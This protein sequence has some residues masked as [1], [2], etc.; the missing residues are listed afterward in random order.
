MRC[1]LSSQ[2]G[3]A[4]SALH[5]STK[6][7]GFLLLDGASENLLF[8]TTT[9]IQGAAA[10]RVSFSYKNPIADVCYFPNQEADSG[11]T[12]RNGGKREGG[13]A[14]ALTKSALGRQ[15]GRGI[16]MRQTKTRWLTTVAILLLVAPLALWAEPPPSDST[17]N[18]VTIDG[19][20]YENCKVVRVE[21][22][23]VVVQHKS[24]GAKVLFRVMSDDL[25]K[26]YGHDPDKERTYLKQLEAAKVARQKRDFLARVKP[27]FGEVA[28]GKVGKLAYPAEIISVVGPDEMIVRVRVDSESI[29]LVPQLMVTRRGPGGD[30]MDYL[31]VPVKAI[32]GTPHVLWTKGIPTDGLV[33]GKKIQL[34]GVYRVTR[35]RTYDT[36]AGGTSTVFV[37]EPFVF[38][39]SP[40]V[41]E[42][43]GVRR[44]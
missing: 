39:S 2:C 44:Q 42:P 1:S 9:P 13:S 10:T 21:P 32:K 5:C 26:K 29:E 19:K 20:T 15:T 36:A 7:S 6:S 34:D 11:G 14:V 35:T 30:E 4:G 31:S 38:S 22:D 8:P 16:H 18:I 17:T 41:P 3:W 28:V 25:K 40:G 23:G 27:F 43:K 37:L 12:A 33:D 24:G